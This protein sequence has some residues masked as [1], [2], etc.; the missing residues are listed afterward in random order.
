MRRG[1]KVRWRSHGATV[2]GTAVRKLTRRTRAAGRVVAAS[3]DRPQWVVR[4]DKT[5]KAAVHRPEALGL[6]RTWP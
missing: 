6:F 4:S 5:G 2:E 3:P 1:D